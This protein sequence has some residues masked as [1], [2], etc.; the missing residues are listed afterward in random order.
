VIGGSVSD[1]EESFTDNCNDRR[2]SDVQ[3]SAG[4]DAKR[5]LN[6]R[7]AKYNFAKLT[8]SR[9]CRYFCYDD[10]GLSAVAS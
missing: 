1:I 8:P 7:P 4:A 6:L 10:A 2:L 9:F 3:F 5:K